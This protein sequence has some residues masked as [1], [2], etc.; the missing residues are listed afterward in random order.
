MSNDSGS[1]SA[2][3][4]ALLGVLRFGWIRDKKSTV[5]RGGD[6]FSFLRVKLEREQVQLLRERVTSAC[7]SCYTGA[8]CAVW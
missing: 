8:G 3:A 4:E 2:S 5:R 1:V 7:M 6:R